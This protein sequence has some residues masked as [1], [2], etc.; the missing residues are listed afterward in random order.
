MSWRKGWDSNPRYGYPY[1]DF[2]S[3]N[4]PDEKDRKIKNVDPGGLEWPPPQ[5]A[6][7]FAGEEVKDGDWPFSFTVI[8]G[9]NDGYPR[10]S[11]VGSFKANQFG[12]YDL[13]GNVDQWCED[14]DESDYYTRW[15][16]GGSWTSATPG[17]LYS[18]SRHRERWD[19]RCDYNGFRCV[20]G[21]VSSQ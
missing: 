17:D 12:L 10:T 16:R 13:A 2:E 8:D 19:H 9:Y 4:R 20:V 6:G 3:G 11:P 5:G 1:A 7:N 15:L 18:S 14:P 21:P